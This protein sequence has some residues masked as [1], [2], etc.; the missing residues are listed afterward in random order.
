MFRSVARAMVPTV[1][2]P[3]VLPVVPL[4]LIMTR[5]PGSPDVVPLNFALFLLL[6]E[7]PHGHWP[8]IVVSEHRHALVA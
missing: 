7:V 4:L 2:N 1:S 5:G 8:N 6:P 3:W